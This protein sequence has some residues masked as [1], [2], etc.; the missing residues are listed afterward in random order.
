MPFIIDNY[1]NFFFTDSENWP[2]DIVGNIMQAR[3]QY[4]PLCP[5][6][7]TIMTLRFKTDIDAPDN[8]YFG[9]DLSN[10][11]VADRPTEPPLMAQLRAYTASGTF[12]A[13]KTTQVYKLIPYLTAE[14]TNIAE[15]EIVTTFKNRTA[16][17]VDKLVIDALLPEYVELA[18]Q[19]AS[20]SV[21]NGQ[22]IISF[23][24]QVQYRELMEL[25]QTYSQESGSPYQGLDISTQARQVEVTVTAYSGEEELASNTMT[26]CYPHKSNLSA[27]HSLLLNQ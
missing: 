2:I 5:G 14:N 21:E 22:T 3:A 17:F 15:S 1:T 19:A 12:L 7:A 13:A 8:P 18:V 11:A 9:L 16:A 24:S 25:T 26:I 27:I 6:D 10:P 23:D 20:V 4:E